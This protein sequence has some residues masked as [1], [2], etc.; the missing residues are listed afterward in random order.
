MNGALRRPLLVAALGLALPAAALLSACSSDDDE[1]AAP[2]AT[3]A[4]TQAAA[5]APTSTPTV[6]PATAATPAAKPGVRSLKAGTATIA[7]DGNAT[8][9]ASV[10]GLEVALKPLPKELWGRDVTTAG[11]PMTA[12]VKVANTATT[13]YVL[14][15]VPDTFTYNP[16]NHNAS[17]ALA[18]EWAVDAEAGVAMGAL[19]PDLKKSGGLVDLWHWELDCGPGVLSGGKFPTGNDSKCNLDDEYATIT[20]E[21]EDDKIDSSLTGSWDHTGRAQGP[22]APGTWVFEIARPLNTGDP[23][24]AQFTAGS[25]SRLA[26]AYWDGNEGRAKDGGW[27]DTGHVVSAVDADEWIE[28]TFAK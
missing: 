27:T 23:Q 5:S 28:V 17:P 10:P 12:T 20:D 2:T 4:A 21:R 11:K 22:E 1:E 15:M 16:K 26:I 9:W 24:D 6:V 18:V 3:Q 7:L 19:K 25:T 13:A 14:V 8:D